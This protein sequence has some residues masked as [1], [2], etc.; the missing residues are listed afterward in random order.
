MTLSPTSTQTVTVDYATANGTATAGSDYVAESGTADLRARCQ[1]APDQRHRQRRHGSGAERDIQRHVE[2]PTNAVLGTAAG[3][4]TILTDDTAPSLPT[5]AIGNAVGGRGQQ[6]HDAG[7]LHG[8]PVAH[9]H[10]DR[11]GRLHD[12]QRHG[13]GR[14]RLRGGERT[15]TFAPGVSTRPITVTVNGDTTVEPN[16]TFSVTLSSATNAVLGTATGTGTILN[17]DAPPATT[18]TVSP[19]TVNPGSVITATVANGP[20]NPRDWAGLFPTGAANADY[21]AWQYF[22]GSETPPAT[23]IGGAT[24]LF[25]APTVPGSYNVRIFANDLISI[26]A[27]TSNTINVQALPALS[28]NSVSVTEGQSG[29]TPAAFT[30]TLSPVSAQTVTV[31]YTT[32]NGTGTA[33]S[34]YVAASGVLT[35]APGV[36]TRPISVI[37]NG[38]TT[39]EPNETVSIVLSGAT[40]AVLGT[41]TGTGTI[42]NYDTA[43]APTVTVSATSV[44]PGSVL[45]VTVANGTGY[46]NDWIGLFATGAPDSTYLAWQFL[47]GATTPPATG[48]TSATLQVIAPTAAGTYNIRLFA[49]VGKSIKVATSATITV[50][51]ATPASVTV[52]PTTVNPSGAITVTVANGAGYAGD[53][54][55]LFTTGAPDSTYLAWQFLNGTTTQ[56][57]TGKTSATLQVVAPTAAGTVQRSPVCQ[58]RGTAS[59]WRRAAR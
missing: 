53:W 59:G 7:H 41:A 19:A 8:D 10:T 26:A 33:G 39:V 47:N 57:A 27:A 52:S 6:R 2:R 37:V 21:V 46:A 34:D 20:G 23:A 35:F 44:N 1:H 4:G 11:H 32:A 14:Q 16:E 38:D 55:G 24:L 51:A 42:T 3:T 25:A 12:G 40:N 50:V 30:V 18:V 43:P 48:V 29:T 15:L 31:N 28:V 49:N 36:S 9:Q 45:T 58:Q 22:N 13:D 54:I 56:P 5:L 17:D